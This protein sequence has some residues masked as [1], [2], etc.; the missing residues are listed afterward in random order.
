MSDRYLVNDCN[1]HYSCCHNSY[2]VSD[3]VK[4][5]TQQEDRPSI[6]QLRAEQAQRRAW[7]R[8]LMRREPANSA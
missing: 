8:R 3:K 2:Q 1:T 4:D 6:A 7:L 5:K